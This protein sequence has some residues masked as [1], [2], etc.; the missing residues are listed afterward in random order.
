MRKKVSES[1]TLLKQWNYKR[2]TNLSPDRLT[3]G[4]NKK[5]WWV[6]NKGH[7]WESAIKNRN[8]RGC[9]YCSGQKIGLDNNLAVLNPSLAKQWHPTKNGDLYPSMFTVGSGKKVWW[10][11]NKGHEWKTAVGHR[12]RVNQPTG[13]P[14]CSNQS[15]EPEVRILTELMS[16]FDDAISRHKIKSL[17]LD[18]YIPSFDIGIE[19][20]GFYYHKDRAPQDNNKN[21]A[22][23]KEGI[24]LVRI[25][26]HPL[27]PISTL[28]IIQVENRLT[29][30]TLDKIM[31]TLKFLVNKTYSEKIKDYLLETKFVNQSVFQK[32]MSYFPDPFPEKSIK[33]LHPKLC[34]EWHYERNK[35]L[36]PSNFPQGS[37]RKVWW[38]CDKG[39]EWEAVI[40]TRARTNQPSGCPY[41]SGQK[42]GLDNNLAVLNPLLAKQWHPTRNGNLY[43][44]MVA[45]SG[46]DNI[47]WVCDKGHEWEASVNSRQKG[48]CPY[49]S[50]R[51]VCSD[52]N[53]AVLNPSLTKQWHP[54]KNDDLFPDMVT[55]GSNK[56]VWWF[57]DKGHEWSAKVVNRKIRGCPYC[58]GRYAS[59]N[60][61]LAI[62]NPS[63][64][65]QWHPIKNGSILPN[66]FTPSSNKKAW[67]VCD[68][69]HEWEA[70]IKRRANPKHPTGCP[71]CARKKR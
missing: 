25:R 35:P 3:Q 70:I 11:C 58:S 57:C 45:P 13:C 51:R 27:Q 64:A 62:L 2:N 60:N 32:Y 49:C 10:I 20:D 30:K 1:E 53:L 23:R 46:K 55:T 17:E 68:K 42:I 37:G 66:M 56:N 40:G 14:Y 61:N 8:K 47:W 67:W 26:E 29:K 69:G 36:L 15:S 52:N 28:D 39:H 12:A 48:G 54:T 24:K 19:Y 71:Y 9:P 43:P 63:L 38:I 59:P 41:C 6:C 7:E 50:G 65:K 5:A 21:K 22:L 16:I 31:L 34:E 18:I 4:S 44:S 33:H